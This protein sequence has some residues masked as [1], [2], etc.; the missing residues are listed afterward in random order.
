MPIFRGFDGPGAFATWLGEQACRTI[1]F[2]KVEPGDEQMLP[3]REQR[4]LDAAPSY[5]AIRDT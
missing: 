3:P 1:R 5:L 2:E 4:E